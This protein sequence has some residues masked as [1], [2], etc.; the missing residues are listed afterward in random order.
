MI[1]RWI[2]T[3][4]FALG[5]T[6]PAVAQMLPAEQAKSFWRPQDLAVVKDG[7]CTLQNRAD[8]KT[9]SFKIPSDYREIHATDEGFW[10]N[11]MT[12]RKGSRD[13]EVYFSPDGTHWH[14]QA[15]WPMR[16]VSPS[17][18]IY[19]MKGGRYLG[20]ATMAP[21]V[22]GEASSFFA[23]LRQGKGSLL[24]I[25]ALL[26]MGIG[27]HSPGWIFGPTVVQAPEGWAV[28]NIRTGHI[29]LVKDTGERVR[30]RTT[31]LYDSVKDSSIEELGSIDPP[32]L[33]CQ[34]AL[35]GT[36]LIAA[37][38]EEAILRAPE[39]R[40]A[41]RKDQPIP[42]MG[43]EIGDLDSSRPGPNPQLEAKLKALTQR[44]QAQAAQVEGPIL[45]KFPELAWWELDPAT[46]RFTKVAAPPGAP[47]Q[48]LTPEVYRAFRFRFDVKGRVVVCD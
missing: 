7:I 1:P 43:E 2:I 33:G 17:C 20:V 44:L 23:V 38:S 32:I 35:D 40:K 8:G 30:I 26:P 6:L 13:N 45:A 10:A 19:A 21:F 48:L 11:R 28:V 9:R 25:D 39:L 22:L 46:S 37:R 29:W 15:T 16:G 47:Q 36:L 24:E 31:K 18:R 14:L 34:P 5:S 41:A 4:V 12:G 3:L 27:K 42:Q